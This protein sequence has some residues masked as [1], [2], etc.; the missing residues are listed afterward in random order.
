MTAVFGRRWGRPDPDHR[1][2]APVVAAWTAHDGPADRVLVAARSGSTWLLAGVHR[3]AAVEPDGSVRWAR[4][5]HEIDS[6]AWGRESGTLTVTFVD[7]G[8]PVVMPLDRE[9]TFLR[10][11]RERVQASVVTSA[12]LPLEGARKA[13]AVIRQDLATGT[14]IE[15]LVLGRGTRASEAI[16]AAAAV[17]FAALREETGLPPR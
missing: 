7:G 14:L 3:F 15:Q 12:D 10:T 5:W 11:L 17:A 4:P 1:P 9:D 2:P 16:D 13:R 6:A 8:R